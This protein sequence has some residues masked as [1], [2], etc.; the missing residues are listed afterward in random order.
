MKL[1]I[2]LCLL[3]NMAIFA[4]DEH[5]DH[6]HHHHKEEGK[7][8]KQSLSAH[9]HGVSV[10]NIVQD[11]NRLSFEFEMPGF[12]VVGFEYKAKK[13][14]DIK[15]VRNALNV[16]SNYKN[17]I[18]IPAEANCE[19]EKKSAKVINEGSHSEFL[20]EYVLNCEST[21][22]YSPK[23]FFLDVLFFLTVFTTFFS[24]FVKRLPSP[25]EPPIGS[26][27]YQQNCPLSENVHEIVWFTLALTA[28]QN[29]CFY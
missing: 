14:D 26:K 7:K 17:M 29:V 23:K 27:P 16:L 3:I 21:I 11:M 8:N 4:E 20:S 9:E 28:S 5:H 25:Y 13:K 19:E 10:L 12:D 6:D 24:K 18:V 2:C 1:L 22:M 15:K